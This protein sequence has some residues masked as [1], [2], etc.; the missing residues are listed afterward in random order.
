MERGE[1][2]GYLGPNGAGKTTTIRLLLGFLRPSGGT[3]K[4]FGKNI[5]EDSLEIRRN[6]GY[7]PGDLSLYGNQT[8]KEFIDYFG[9]LRGSSLPLLDDLLERFEVP[10]DRKIE[11]YSK[12]MR[13]KIAIIQAFMHDPDLVIMDEPTAGLDPLMQERIYEFLQEQRGRGKTV[14]FS[15]HVLS[16]AERVCDRVAIIREGY[17]IALEDVDSLKDKH[18]KHVRVKIAGNPRSFEGP[19][20]MKVGDDGWIEFVV[21]GDIDEWIKKLSCH[22]VLDLEIGDFH[23]EDIFMHYYEGAEQ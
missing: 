7:V 5:V 9:S 20:N 2:F 10:L 22:T 17:L 12:G 14:F 3:G 8:G 6:L 13:Q 18:G 21:S 4:I 23:L 1:I 19:Q 15:S 11:S 16:E